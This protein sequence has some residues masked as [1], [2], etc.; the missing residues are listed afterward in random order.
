MSPHW[1]A[2]SQGTVN[3]VDSVSSCGWMVGLRKKVR[4]HS[5]DT[6]SNPFGASEV[7]QSTSK[8]YV[9]TLPEAR[10]FP[11]L[12]LVLPFSGVLQISAGAQPSSA[13]VNPKDTAP[14]SCY[15]GDLLCSLFPVEFLAPRDH[16]L[17]LSHCSSLVQRKFHSI[18]LPPG[19]R[20]MCL[21][22]QS[23]FLSVLI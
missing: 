22:L 14:S 18:A 16:A 5:Q 20:D 3:T 8:Y 21:L 4:T 17:S 11:E 13:N 15:H 7:C 1:L 12:T 9:K 6:C 23:L 2:C 19:T 10:P